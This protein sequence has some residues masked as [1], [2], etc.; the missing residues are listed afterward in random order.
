MLDLSATATATGSTE[1]IDTTA[2]HGY[3]LR[4]AYVGAR[5]VAAEIEDAD[6]VITRYNN[7]TS[8][9]ADF[10]ALTGVEA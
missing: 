9:R 1:M 7:P 10:L 3:I 6:S 4:I 8:A 2:A 5:E